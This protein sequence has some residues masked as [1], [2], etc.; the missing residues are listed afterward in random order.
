M[1]TNKTF[2]IEI[3][4]GPL[5]L[6]SEQIWP[7]GDGPENPNTHDVI[8]AIHDVPGGL[9]TVLTTWNLDYDLGLEVKDGPTPKAV[10]VLFCEH[11]E[12]MGAYL[13]AGKTISEAYDFLQPLPTDRVGI[14][15]EI[16]VPISTDHRCG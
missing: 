12:K 2:Y 5:L 6:D 13:L 8:K 1:N 10:A 14:M 3:T 16:Q 7:D 4:T 9:R 11:G 15:D